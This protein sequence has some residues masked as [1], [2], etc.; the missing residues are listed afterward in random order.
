MNIDKKKRK[1]KK[2]KNKKF[3]EIK[4]QNILGVWYS[5]KSE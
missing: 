1:R 2:E 4:L 5:T 3:C